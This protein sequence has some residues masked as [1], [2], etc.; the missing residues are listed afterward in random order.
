VAHV[1]LVTA[2]FPTLTPTQRLW[3]RAYRSASGE[4]RRGLA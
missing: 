1:A 3:L 2:D 4:L